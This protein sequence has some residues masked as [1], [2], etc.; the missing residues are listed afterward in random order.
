[1]TLDIVFHWGM[2]H[3]HKAIHRSVHG[4]SLHAAWLY[5]VRHRVRPSLFFESLKFSSVAKVWRQG[6]HRGSEEPPA[7]PWADWQ[8]PMKGLG[9]NPQ[10]P[11]IG[12]H[13][14]S[15]ADKRTPSQPSTPSK[16]R[17]FANPRTH[18]GWACAHP[19]PCPPTA[20][21]YT[22]KHNVRMW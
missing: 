16:L 9:Q 5:S 20:T 6:V 3:E 22:C 8:N 13:A 18:V 21:V 2:K 4:V 10:K 1:M 15:T 11:D 19:H 12:L 7:V 14:Q 17:I